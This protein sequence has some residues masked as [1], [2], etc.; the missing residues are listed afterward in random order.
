MTKNKEKVMTIK[1]TI[2]MGMI[3]ILLFSTQAFGAGFALY[4]HSARAVA[5]GGAFVAQANDPSAIYYNPAGITQLTGSWMMAGVTA[6]IPK[7]SIT[8]EKGKKEETKDKTFYPPHFYITQQ[9]NETF[10]FGLGANAPFGLSTGF[11]SNWKGRYNSY[12]A[13]VKTLTLNPNLVIKASDSI[14]LAIGFSI[15]RTD[16]GFKQK[17]SPV[18]VVQ[19]NEKK[20]KSG[21]AYTSGLDPD[22]PN[23]DLIYKTKFLDSAADLDDIDQEVEGRDT[24]PGINLALHYKATERLSIGITYRFKTTANLK[25]NTY[26]KNVGNLSGV[27]FNLSDFFYNATGSAELRMPDFFSIGT[28]YKLNKKIVME[29]DFWMTGW[30]S[31]NELPIIFQN[32]LGDQ[33][34]RKSYKDVWTFRFGLEYKHSDTFTG[35][36]GY[37]YDQSPIP[38]DTIDYMLPSND[39]QLINT[40]IGFKYRNYIIDAFYSYLMINDRHINERKEDFVFEGDIKGDAHMIGLSISYSF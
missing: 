37:V 39:R 18:H 16:A 29:A 4:E 5:L 1:K 3:S 17:I 13:L 23:V 19:K 24:S 20:I 25:G 38:D 36:L 30:S 27:N 11:D 14:S 7:L 33:T 32:A 22:S 40:G 10:W 34:K 21:I 31:Y 8:D 9:L 12:T 35:R 26:Y 15:H 2:L 28:A 6:I